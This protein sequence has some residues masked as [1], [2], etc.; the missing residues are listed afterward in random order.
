MNTV[1]LISCNDLDVC[2]GLQI[3]LISV[4]ICLVCLIYSQYVFLKKSGIE[5]LTS[6]LDPYLMSVD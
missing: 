1:C 3:S 5:A 2:N 4:R 6:W